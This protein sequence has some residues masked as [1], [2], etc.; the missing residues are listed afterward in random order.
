[1]ADIVNH[2]DFDFNRKTLLYF[3]GWI[4][5]F[6]SESSQ[7][8]AKAYIERGDHNI[9][10]GDWGRYSFSEYFLVI[11]RFTQIARTVGRMVF[12]MIE[13]GLDVETLHCVGHSFG[14]HICGIVGRTVQ[15][16]SSGQYKINRIS[17]L[18]PAFYGFYPPLIEGPI[19]KDDAEF[20][21][22]IHTDSFWIGSPY[23]AG[24]VSFFPNDAKIQPG[25]P[26]LR[27]AG[28]MDFINNFC[29]HQHAWRY[30]S[31]SVKPARAQGFPALRCKTYKN[32]KNNL[33]NDNPVN[34]MGYDASPNVAGV[35]YI[36]LQSRMNYIVGDEYY[37]YLSTAINN[38]SDL[39]LVVQTIQKFFKHLLQRQRT[40][41]NMI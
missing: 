9:I 23:P 39:I 4:E 30:W 33:C 40:N 21:D 36:E 37:Q 18:D 27:F 20:V 11:P 10:M 15:Q 28:Y 6:E 41:S 19:S 29:S 3:H 26:P 14:S 25:C 24:H 32:F 31:E 16:I 35:F 12:E 5:D 34:F 8:I 13:S 38:R 1:M 22:T 7:T 17:G 2:D